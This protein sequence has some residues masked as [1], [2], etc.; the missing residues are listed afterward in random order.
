MSDFNG[1][2]DRDDAMRQNPRQVGGSTVPKDVLGPITHPQADVPTLIP[3]QATVQPAKP[4]ADT[5]Q[6]LGPSG[7]SISIPTVGKSGK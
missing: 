3:I 7:S 6:G 1:G 4:S 5:G 2:A